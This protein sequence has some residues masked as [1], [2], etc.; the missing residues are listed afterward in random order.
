MYQLPSTSWSETIPADDTTE[1]ILHA[2]V[3][4]LTNFGVRRTTM[5]DVARRAGVSRVT[6]YRRFDTKN[7]LVQAVVLRETQ[8]FF[9]RLEAAISQFD[10]PSERLAEGFAFAL[11][12]LRHH[13]LVNRL[14]EIEPEAML[15]YLTIDGGS[16][17]SAARTYL[18]M[19][20][21]REVLEKRWPE[22]DISVMS[23]LLARMVLSFFLTPETIVR[24]RT[25]DDARAFARRYFV[26]ILEVTPAPNDAR[27][28]APSDQTAGRR[29][30][31]AD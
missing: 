3:D 15:P 23:E 31:M 14:M 11:H 21:G 1:R 29:G 12:Y 30:P 13:S 27:I 25:R 9:G 26:P 16:L 10:D 20:M 6:V 22:I 24:L 19:Q 18:G 2:A 17:V 8:L 5:D 28:S 7:H 4:Q